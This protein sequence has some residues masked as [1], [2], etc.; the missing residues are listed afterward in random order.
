MAFATIAHEGAT[1]TVD[2]KNITMPTGF[3]ILAP[4]ET[5]D[6]LFTQAELDEKI[7]DRL[8]RER[9]KYEKEAPSEDDVLLKGPDAEAYRLL[10]GDGK[11]GDVKTRLD[12]AKTA[13][14]ELT[15]LR[16]RQE[17]S[18]VAAVL[19]WDAGKLERLAGDL[20]FRVEG[21]EGE[22]T[23]KVVSGEEGA[24][25]VLASEHDT[26]KPFLD[27][28]VVGGTA[29]QQRTHVPQ[30]PPGSPGKPGEAV[31]EAKRRKAKDYHMI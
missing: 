28:L 11:I 7:A 27:A 23:V 4:N 20:T 5:P 21:D 29:P 3:R 17:F 18:E 9:T 19:G 2:T 14:G 1:L 22:K 30:T 31:E 26:F 6:G 13:E 15:T 10:V 16:R 25:P 12:E 24:K 8:K